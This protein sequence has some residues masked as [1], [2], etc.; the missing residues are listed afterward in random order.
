MLNWTYKGEILKR[1]NNSDWD[2]QQSAD[3]PH[4]SIIIG[5]SNTL[6]NFGGNIGCRT[7]AER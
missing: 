7:W 6:E 1:K 4:Y 5:G 3:T 2:S